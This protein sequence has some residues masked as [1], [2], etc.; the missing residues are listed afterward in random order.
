M[1]LEIFIFHKKQLL[2]ISH[3]EGYKLK[4]TDQNAGQLLHGSIDALQ[5]LLSVFTDARKSDRI[6]YATDQYATYCRHYPTGI[7][8]AVFSSTASADMYDI[9]DTVYAGFFVPHVCRNPLYVRWTPID[10]L[11]CASFVTAMRAIHGESLS[12]FR[13]VPVVH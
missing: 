10:S 2:F 12:S 13:P 6:A 7:S 3:A 11:N 5:K 4:L 1:I 8:I 9:L